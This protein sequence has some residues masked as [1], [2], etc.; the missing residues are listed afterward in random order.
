MQEQGGFYLFVLG[1][2]LLGLILDILT[3]YIKPQCLHLSEILT[4]INSLNSANFYTSA[5]STM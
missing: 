2:N 4:V 5:I 1:G 3:V